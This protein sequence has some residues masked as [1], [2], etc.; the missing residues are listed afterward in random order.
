VKCGLDEKGKHIYQHIISL[1][2]CLARSKLCQQ[3][4]C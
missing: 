4:V 2:T 1:S 3:P